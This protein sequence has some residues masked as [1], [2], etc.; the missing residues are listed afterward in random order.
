MNRRTLAWW[1][2]Q[3]KKSGV[4]S[5]E[6]APNCAFTELVVAKPDA[7]LVLSLDRVAASVIVTRETDLALLKRL[8]LALA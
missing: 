8:L 5:N 7:P 2:S 3:L 1:R 6:A 4:P